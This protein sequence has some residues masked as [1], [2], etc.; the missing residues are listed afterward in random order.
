MRADVAAVRRAYT[1]QVE[2]GVDGQV[3][4]E[5]NRLLEATK[6]IGKAA[7]ASPNLQHHKLSLGAAFDLAIK[8]MEKKVNLC[9]QE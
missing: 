2:E 4:T 9:V 8:V 7:K 1:A 6:V 3:E 5:F